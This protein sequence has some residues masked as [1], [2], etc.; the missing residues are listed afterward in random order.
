MARDPQERPSFREVLEVLEP[1]GADLHSGSFLGFSTRATRS[2]G[3]AGA[4]GGLPYDPRLVGE[5]VGGGSEA[6]E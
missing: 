5:D 3:G 1:L 6:D 4:G 2:R